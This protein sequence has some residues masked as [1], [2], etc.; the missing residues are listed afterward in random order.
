MRSATLLLLFLAIAGAYCSQSTGRELLDTTQDI[1]DEAIDDIEDVSDYIVDLLAP[2]AES[3][4]SSPPLPQNETDTTALRSAFSGRKLLSKLHNFAPAIEAAKA[5]AEAWKEDAEDAVNDLKESVTGRKLS[6]AD[7]H[8][9]SKF[10]PEIESAKAQ[11]E[12]W[13]EDAQ[14]AV[15]D[16][17][18]SVTGRKLSSADGHFLSKFA[19]EIESAKAQ[20]EAWKEDAQDAVDDL[21][22]SVTG[23]KLS[24]LNLKYKTIPEFAH[25]PEI[26]KT[27]KAFDAWSQSAQDAAE[28]WFKLSNGRKLQSLDDIDIDYK[29]T[30]YGD[31]DEFLAPKI[32]EL[33]EAK[34]AAIAALKSKIVDPFG[35][36]GRKLQ[37][38]DDIDIDYKT[39]H[40]GDLDEF[41]APKIEELKDAKD[42]AIAALKSKLSDP[43]GKKGRKLQS[44]DEIDIDYKTT[45]YGDLDE[46][47]APK[48]EELKEAKDA[49]IAALKSKIVDPFGKHSRKLQ[50]LDD[51]DIDY[52]TTHYGDLDEF[53]APKIEELKEA[54]DA[55][56]AALKSKIVDPFKN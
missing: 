30:H 22:E 41:L 55:A 53:L 12:A 24:T 44:L 49:A 19:P 46:F 16:L 50:S 48:I 11:A 56:I 2:A 28:K 8:F 23:R 7:G 40:Y 14:D 37:S 15:N 4:F 42:A 17:K 33:K 27:K 43:F 5:Q 45:H 51:I 34:D 35:K 54:K 25:A 13:K 47:L 20:A 3:A 9:L 6:S 38:L 26:E 36:K 32:E 21:K 52:K 18:E 39:T 29:T 1:I 10:A 31:L